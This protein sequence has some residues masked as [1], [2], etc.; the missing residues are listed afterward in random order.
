MSLSGG[1]QRRVQSDDEWDKEVKKRVPASW[2]DLGSEDREEW[3][4]TIPWDDSKKKVGEAERGNIGHI[5]DFL[6]SKC[7]KNYNFCHKMYYNKDFGAINA[8]IHRI[9]HLH[10]LC[11]LS[12]TD[13]T[14]TGDEETLRHKKKTLL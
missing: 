13:T 11:L 7:D 4:R 8:G 1:G 2:I 6:Q 14:I 3:R 12:W 5:C 9:K 10:Q